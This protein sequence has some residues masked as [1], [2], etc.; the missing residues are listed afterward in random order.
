MEPTT[1]RRAVEQELGALRRATPLPSDRFGLLLPQSGH[2]SPVNRHDSKLPFSIVL[3]V[4]PEF[5]RY[6][7]QDFPKQ[8]PRL[9]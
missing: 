2:T 3:V 9:G 5:H 1:D 8:V 4:W 7:P 6:P